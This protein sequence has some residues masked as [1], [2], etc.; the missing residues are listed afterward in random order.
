MRFLAD[1]CVWRVVVEALRDIGWDGDWIH[2]ISPGLSDLEI[3]KLSLSGSCP[4]VTEDADFGDLIF[5]EGLEAYGVVRV[6][7][8]AFQGEKVNTASDVAGRMARLGDGL[9]GQF[10]TIEPNRTRQRALPVKVVDRD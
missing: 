5:R 2:E 1:Q 10:T 3:V 4:I 9:I 8:S 6:R 7:L